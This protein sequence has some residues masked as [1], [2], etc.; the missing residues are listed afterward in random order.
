MTVRYLGTLAISKTSVRWRLML[1]VRLLASHVPMAAR[2]VEKAS[3][4]KK[5]WNMI[6]AQCCSNEA[7]VKACSDQ[8]WRCELS[9]LRINFFELSDYVHTLW[10][11]TALPTS[12]LNRFGKFHRAQLYFNLNRQHSLSQNK[13]VNQKEKKDS[14]IYRNFKR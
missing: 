13:D 7:C 4:G 2:S 3:K 1:A 11:R 14:M 5:A 9:G 10:P 6:L 12:T 8:W